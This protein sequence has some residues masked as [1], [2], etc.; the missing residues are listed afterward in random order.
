MKLNTEAQQ[1]TGGG[2]LG[3]ISAGRLE[4]TAQDGVFSVRGSW[5]KACEIQTEKC[6]EENL[7]HWIFLFSFSDNNNLSR[8]G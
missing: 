3:V 6:K 7:L 5:R 1:R 2:R 8:W 4:A